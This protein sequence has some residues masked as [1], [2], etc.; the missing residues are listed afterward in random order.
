MI[1]Y[2]YIFFIKMFSIDKY[3]GLQIKYGKAD[4]KHAVD[5]ADFYFFR[6]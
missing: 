1:R 4:C 2:T 5:A 6:L 3:T